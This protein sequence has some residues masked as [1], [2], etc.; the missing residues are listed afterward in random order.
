MPCCI[1]CVVHDSATL[2][3]CNCTRIS[4]CVAT[5]VLH[6]AM[7]VAMTM[8]VAMFVTMI[9]AMTMLHYAIHASAVL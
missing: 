6:A 9:V 4:P 2:I 5:Q 3:V 7:R 1:S 8:I